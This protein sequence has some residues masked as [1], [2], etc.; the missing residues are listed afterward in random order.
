MAGLASSVVRG[1]AFEQN[2]VELLTSYRFTLHRTGG[3]NDRGVDFRG[4]W[5]PLDGKSIPV[6][7]QCKCQKRRVG[8]DAVRE[9][10]AAVISQFSANLALL[11]SAS[12]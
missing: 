9:L 3:P 5:K 8:P 1:R 2:V 6:I 11:V 4:F 12:G 10:H 7:G